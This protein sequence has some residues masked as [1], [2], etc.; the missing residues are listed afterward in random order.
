M[1][2]LPLRPLA[3]RVLHILQIL[4]LDAAI[5]YACIFQCDSTG[6]R[7]GT[8]QLGPARVPDGTPIRINF[9]L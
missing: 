2:A 4:P 5:N 7:D 3:S 9:F 8:G 6:R 1:C